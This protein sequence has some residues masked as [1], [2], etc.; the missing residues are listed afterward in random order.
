MRKINLDLAQLKVET[1]TAGEDWL[2]AFNAECTQRLCSL[3]CVQPTCEEYV[4]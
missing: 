2:K 1:F 3:P 4:C